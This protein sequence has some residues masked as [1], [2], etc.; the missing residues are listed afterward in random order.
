MKNVYY[1]IL[2]LG[3]LLFCLTLCTEPYTP[4]EIQ[5]KHN[6]LVVDGFVNSGT[7]SSFITLS[8]SKN[9]GDER[10]IEYENT[11]QMQLEGET[12]SIHQFVLLKN[13]VYALPVLVLNAN[14]NYRLRIKLKGKEYLSEQ[15]P[16]TQSP[17]IDSISWKQDKN[18]VRILANTHDVTDKSRYY[19]WDFVE[20]WEYVSKYE[21]LYK[22]ENG[23]LKRRNLATEDINRCWKTEVSHSVNLGTTAGLTKDVIYEVPIHTI[24]F[25]SFRLSRK[26]SILVKQYVVTPKAFDYWLNMK[27]NTEQPGS[28]FD[29]QPSQISSNIHCLTTPEEPVIGYIGAGTI[30]KQRIFVDKTQLLPHFRP[31][32]YDACKIDSF[33]TVLPPWLGPGPDKDPDWV[34]HLF[35]N[36]KRLPI[37]VTYI[38]DTRDTICILSLKECVDCRE[39]GGVTKKPDFWP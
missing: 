13:G 22:Y 21:S 26:Y 30:K 32:E 6:Y 11:A 15:F 29:P 14:T 16:V 25:S 31:N 19:K 23:K 24:P 10:L 8:R 2:G 1:S 37:R 38:P 33:Y 4:P 5:G 36:G 27:K 7:D 35:S 34:W 39:K 20:T 9:I 12:G 17:E 18:G 28:I 3:F